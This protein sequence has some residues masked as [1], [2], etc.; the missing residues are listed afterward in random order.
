MPIA[1]VCLFI[2]SLGPLRKVPKKEWKL[3]VSPQN[4][5]VP[6]TETGS[7]REG[8]GCWGAGGVGFE[9]V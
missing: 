4:W 9:F 6:L 3:V 2:F 5:E 1:I 8:R 7:L